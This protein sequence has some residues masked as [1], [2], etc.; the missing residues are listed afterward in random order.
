MI[1]IIS[2]Y[3]KILMVDLQKKVFVV[4]DQAPCVS[5]LLG[6][7][8]PNLLV[9]RPCLDYKNARALVIVR[10]EVQWQDLSGSHV[11]PLTYN[12]LAE[13]YGISKPGLRHAVYSWTFRWKENRL[14][15]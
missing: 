5:E 12:H 1:G 14:K 15:L 11:A 7:S 3:T 9:S 6:F 10:C 8:L 4:R 2:T 13:L